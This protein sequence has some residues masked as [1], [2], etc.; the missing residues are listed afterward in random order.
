MF[1]NVVIVEEELDDVDIDD[2]GNQQ[3]LLGVVFID[4]ECEYPTVVV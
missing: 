4:E 1:L 2:I 3:N